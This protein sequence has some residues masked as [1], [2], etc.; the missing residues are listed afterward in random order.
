M[1]HII[2]PLPLNTYQNFRA[3]KNQLRSL[4]LQ[5]K[6]N[7]NFHLYTFADVYLYIICYNISTYDFNTG[8]S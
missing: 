6:N 5:G 3:N 1:P 7:G 8:A 4:L 2:Q